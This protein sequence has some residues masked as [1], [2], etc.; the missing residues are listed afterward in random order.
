MGSKEVT[1][2][3]TSQAPGQ[4][5]WAVLNAENQAC[6]W[7]CTPTQLKTVSS[8]LRLPFAPSHPEIYLAAAKKACPLGWN[9]VWW[10]WGERWVRHLAKQLADHQKLD[11]IS[12]VVGER[13]GERGGAKS[14][15]PTIIA[16]AG[17]LYIFFPTVFFYCSLGVTVPTVLMCR[18]SV[19]KITI[20]LSL[21]K[22]A[23]VLYYFP[24]SLLVFLELWYCS[25]PCHD[26]TKA[27]EFCYQER[28][29]D[30]VKKGAA[31]VPM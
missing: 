20:P 30:P 24:V 19:S 23:Q 10:D 21:H 27:G 8:P 17:W 18:V 29:S 15:K 26:L 9:A 4:L 13:E 2:V 3:N 22:F 14:S 11:Q 28:C 6:Y 1:Q 16:L 7:Q 25:L 12:L 31:E 5:T